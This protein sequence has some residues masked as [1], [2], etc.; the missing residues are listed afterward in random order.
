MPKTGQTTSYAAG[1]DGALQQGVAWPS[2]RFTTN[3]DKTITD[4][5]TGLVWDPDGGTP[6]VG[7]CAGGAKNW[8]GALNYVAC[9]NASNY[10]GRNDWRLPNINEI[11]SLVHAGQTNTATWLNSQGFTNVQRGFYWSS[12]TSADDGTLAWFVHIV[13]GLARTFTKESTNYVWPV[14]TGQ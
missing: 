6:T 4:N 11:K 14:R 2:P 10:L 13:D 8:Q 3:A 7:A 1:D 12:T 5:L 9:L